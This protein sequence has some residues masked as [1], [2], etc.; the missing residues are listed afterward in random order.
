M[1]IE[2]KRGRRG[3]KKKKNKMCFIT[4]KAY[5]SFCSSIIYSFAPAVQ[6]LIEK[7]K[8]ALA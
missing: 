2:N 3:K 5:F 1:S 4:W 7:L 8:L 6:R